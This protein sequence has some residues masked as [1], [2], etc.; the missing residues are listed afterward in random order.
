[1]GYKSFLGQGALPTSL[2]SINGDTA[3]AQ[4][5]DCLHHYSPGQ[6]A[7]LRMSLEK[8]D[9]LILLFTIYA[10]G[11]SDHCEPRCSNFASGF[12]T[13]VKERVRKSFYFESRTC[14]PRATEIRGSVSSHH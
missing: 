6:L 7:G 8:V 11:S 14:H 1:M 3:S 2:P 9:A 12:I 13:V 10:S 4:D 5:N